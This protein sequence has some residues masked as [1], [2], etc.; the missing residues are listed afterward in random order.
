MQSSHREPLSA[1]DQGQG[2]I[3][4]DRALWPSIQ[5]EVSDENMIAASQTVRKRTTELLAI[6]VALLFLVVPMAEAAPI[7]C[8]RHIA[9]NEHVVSPPGKADLHVEKET[10][11]QKACCKPV[12]GMCYAMFPAPIWGEVTLKSG[13]RRDLAAQS[14]ISGIT[15]RPAIGPPRS[16]G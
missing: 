8:G 2:E 11:G 4:Q 14:P 15:S 1:F 10:G 5:H 16:A 3:S 13:E 9:G 7:E 6:L 12:C